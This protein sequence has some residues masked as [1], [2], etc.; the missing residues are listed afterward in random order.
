MNFGKQDKKL[1]SKVF[2]WFLFLTFSLFFWLARLWRFEKLMTFHLDQALFMREVWQ[3]VITRKLRLVGPMVTSKVVLGRG[4]FIGPALYYL[5]AVLAI[6]T[7]WDVILITKVLIFVWWFAALGILVWLARRF[8]WLAGLAAYGVFASLPVL[9]DYSRLMWNPNF[10]PL[11]GLGFFWLLEEM[12]G[13]D[14][15]WQWLLLGFLF[16]LGINFHYVAFLWGLIFLP[17]LLVGIWRRRY[18]FYRL[19]FVL[20]VLGAILGDLPIVIFDLRHNFYNLKTILFFYLKEGVAKGE[21]GIA[22]GGYFLF[23]LIPVFFWL[24]SYLIYQFEKK[25]G[26]FKTTSL[27]LVIFLFLV[28]KIDWQQKW[29]TGMPEGWNIKKQRL[30]ANSVCQEVKKEKM[31][32]EFEIAATISGDTRAGD[33]RWWLSREGCTPLGVEDYPKADV[34]YLVA[35]EERTPEKETV[36]EVSVMRPFSIAESKSLEDGIMFYKLVRYKKP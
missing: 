21:G 24:F 18:K 10:L 4:F 16:G 30:V 14:K 27:I 20:F 29:G 23:A 33:L 13:K 6:I 11:I 7:S 36:W 32:G 22:L 5:L 19:G 15:L 9:I 34:L 35:P 12:W 3:M 26:F 1:L 8:S 28:L 17:L 2:F 31:D 25:F